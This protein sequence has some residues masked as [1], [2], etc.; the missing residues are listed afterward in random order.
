MITYRHCQALSLC[1]LGI[2]FLVGCTRH[3][4]FWVSST[5]REIEGVRSRTLPIDGAL[6][7]KSEPVRD[8]FSVRATWEIQTKNDSQTYFQW[9]KNQLGPDYHVTSESASAVTLVK[10]IEGDSYTVA[11]RSSGAP[12]GVV[13]EAQ[14][15]AA[16]D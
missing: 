13:V 5:V 12:G 6:L 4:Q 14:F 8:S 10:G 9:L 11:F 7:R 3:Q 2:V 15:V 16:P 1:S